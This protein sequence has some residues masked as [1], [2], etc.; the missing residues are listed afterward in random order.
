MENVMNDVK[1]ACPHCNKILTVSEELCGTIVVCPS[2]GMQVQTLPLSR[3]RK[4]Q[5]S[6]GYT[7]IGGDGQQYGPVSPDQLRQWVSEGR[8]DA[9]TRVQVAGATDWKPLGELPE[10]AGISVAPSQGQLQPPPLASRTDAPPS[11]T[12]QL[13]T[14]PVAVAILLHYVTFGLFTMV[15][16]NLMHG[17]M[18]RVRADD[19]SAARAIGFCF[20]PFFNLYWIFFTFNRLCLRIDEQRGLYGLPASNLGGLAI[21]SCIFKIIPYLNLLIGY[22]IISPIFIGMMQASINKLARTSETTAPLKTLPASTV[23]APG[24]HGCAI[25]A[26]VFVCIIP[27]IGILSA[28]A[29]PNFLRAREISQRNACYHNLS[30][31]E[32]SKEQAALEHNYPDGKAI[33]EQD[34][35][36]YLPK[37]VSGLTCHKGGQYTVNP[38]GKPPECSVHGRRR[39]VR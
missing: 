27:V 33:P 24:M 26:I 8:V 5:S 11:P 34:L 30:I 19:P 6:S 23:P 13:T 3:L 31:L 4:E 29:I 20:I 37:G 10:F 28:I 39:E 17:R 9:T 12:H 32:A 1:N 7:I 25:A 21:T 22:L 36:P 15:W 38:S 35:A 18:C 14:F 16:L 2:C